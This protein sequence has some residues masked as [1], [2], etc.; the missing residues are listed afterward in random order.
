M[1]N[2]Y[3]KESRQPFFRRTDL[4][5]QMG[6]LTQIRLAIL[7][8]QGHKSFTVEFLFGAIFY[9]P[10]TSWKS[11]LVN[12][13]RWLRIW[14]CAIY[15]KCKMPGIDGSTPIQNRSVEPS[16]SLNLKYFL[17][18]SALVQVSPHIFFSTSSCLFET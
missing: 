6:C 2:I 4:Q 13:R 18:S 17:Q 3:I 14:S 5:L 15:V 10:E 1:T 16:T 12:Q 7:T 8:R 11:I 9:L